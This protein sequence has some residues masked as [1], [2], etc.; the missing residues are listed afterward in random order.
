M[1]QKKFIQ[2]CKTV[3]KFIQ[4]YCDHEH[5]EEKNDGFIELIY[6]S[7][8]LNMQ[9]HYNLCDECKDTLHYSYKRL[10]ECPY[11]EKTSCRKCSE[12]CYD[13]PKWKLLAKIMRYSGLRLGFI[14]VKKMF[15]RSL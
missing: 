1:K 7:E 5:I 11:E 12:P 9:I 6:R 13:R 2:D 10:Q 3:S 14:K 8:D 15:T 4:Y